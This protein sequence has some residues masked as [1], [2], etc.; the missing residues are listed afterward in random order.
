MD[1][2][3]DVESVVELDEQ[4]IENVIVDLLEDEY[5]LSDEEDDPFQQLEENNEEATYKVFIKN[6]TNDFETIII[7]DVEKDEIN[8]L[9]RETI[10]QITDDD[11]KKV[12]EKLQP[13]FIEKEADETI[14]PNKKNFFRFFCCFISKKI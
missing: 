5:M 10:D 2:F 11:V 14:T 6:F 12:E 3:Y 13:V 9:I 7:E 4:S 1:L 8:K